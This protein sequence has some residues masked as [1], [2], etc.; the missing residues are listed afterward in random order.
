MANCIS[1]KNEITFDYQLV[2]T[3]TSGQ[4]LKNSTLTRDLIQTLDL[5]NLARGVYF[6]QFSNDKLHFVKRIVKM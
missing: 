4:I 2:I 6:L 5:Q 1:F 3:N